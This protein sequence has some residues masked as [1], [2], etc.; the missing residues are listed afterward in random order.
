MRAIKYKDNNWS[1]VLGNNLRP[2]AWFDDDRASVD[3]FLSDGWLK[4]RCNRK[5]PD[6]PRM[7]LQLVLF[8]G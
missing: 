2:V 7:S 5:P 4:L 1:I 3:N 6:I 8:G